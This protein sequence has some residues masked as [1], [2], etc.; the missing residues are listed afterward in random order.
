MNIIFCE[1]C[2]SRNTIEDEVLRDIEHNKI[3]CQVC[4]FPISSQH[5]IDHTGSK[6]LIDTSS[7]KLLFIDDDT[8][9]L[10]LLQTAL[11]KEYTIYT[12]TSGAEGLEMAVSKK[13]DII[14]LD[15]EMP[16]MNGYDVCTT[17][18]NNKETRH[19]PII[20]ITAKTEGDKIYKGLS[21][22]AVDYIVKPCNIK[23]LN[24]KIASHLRFTAMRNEL[25]KKIKTHQNYIE[26]LKEDIENDELTLQETD[27]TQQ[28]KGNIAKAYSDMEKR[29][30]IDIVNTLSDFVSIQ[31]ID[32]KILW[33][34]TSV[35]RAFG[36]V[37]FELQNKKCYNTYWNR[38]TPCDGC[39]CNDTTLDSPTASEE[40][41]N[42]TLGQTLLQTRLALHDNNKNIVAIACL[43]QPLLDQNANENPLPKLLPE[44]D[45]ELPAIPIGEFNDAISTLLISS[46][47][48]CNMYK[49]D[50]NLARINQYIND[51]S[52]TLRTLVAELGKHTQKK[53]I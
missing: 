48:M 12:A 51:A 33:A 13:P 19:I 44:V 46:D 25:Q 47:T 22:G 52:N 53:G 6:R 7:Y 10:T 32:G 2:G 41:F 23:I 3:S 40:R 31:D 21:M 20:F 17:L 26:I 1:E 14:L 49:H 37:F 43:A 30:L 4:N 11:E 42:T 27:K 50:E 38:T 8:A 5:L 28:E 9:H 15:V 18:K 36:V 24:A 16:V 39:I 29:H 45:E 34:N 35:M